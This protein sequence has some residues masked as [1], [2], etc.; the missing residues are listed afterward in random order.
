M[1]IT[2]SEALV[3]GAS[4]SAI[5]ALAHIAC[6]FAGAPA[7]R[8][9]SAGERMARAAQAGKRQPTLI[10]LALSSVLL[11]WAAYALGA[12]G[13]IDL[14]PLSKLVLPVIVAVYLGRA[15]A[16]PLL[17]PTFPENSNTFWLVSSG[18]CL[19]IGVVHLYGL[20][21]VWSGLK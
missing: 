12:A 9:L 2:G 14:L 1:F 16:F 10:T 19:F 20:T 7:Y 6:I 11:V 21:A 8:L 18:I 13:V 5:A 17:K 4:L 15:V 3:L